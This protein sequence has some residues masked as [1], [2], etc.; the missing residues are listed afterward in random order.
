MAP[1]AQ[2]KRPTAA[3][4]KRPAAAKVAKVAKVAKASAMKTVPKKKPAAVG[5]KAKATTA[6]RGA[7][8]MKKARKSE[9]VAPGDLAILGDLQ[10]LLLG[11]ERR[12]DRRKRCEKMLTE[13]VPWLAVEF[14]R[15]SDG[16]SDVIPD[17][18]VAKTWNTKNNSLY[19]SYEDVM[20]KDGKVLYTAAQFSKPGVDYEFSPGERGCA[21]S[22]YRMWQRVAVSD[23]PMLIL[24]D[25]VQLDF[26]R[27]DSS[28]MTGEIFTERL[29]LGMHEAYSN[30]ADVLYLGWSGFRDGNYK[31]IKTRG[32]PTTSGILRKAEYVWTTVAYVLWP[33]GAK[34]LL[35]KARPMNQPVD[36]FM[37]WESREGRLSSWV[38]LDVGDA[39]DTWSGGIVTQLDFTGDSDIKKSDGGDQGDDPTFY[40]AKKPTPAQP[41]AKKDV[42]MKSADAEEVEAVAE[43]DAAEEDDQ[44]EEAPEEPVPARAAA[45]EASAQEEAAEASQRSAE[46]DAPAEEGGAEEAAAADEEEAA[47]EEEEEENAEEAAEEA[48][49]EGAPE[50]ATAEDAPA[51]D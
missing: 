23:T 28:R 3:V 44:D 35:A 31:H 30:G 39:D 11:L 41:A 15:A 17:K 48:P 12:P 27:T 45:E 29:A 46:A 47:E 37:G 1:K 25:D 5:R 19:G 24:E 6:A 50:E 26:E 51:E 4:L 14:F 16:K 22:H 20:G 21:H 13:H 9:V 43:G 36:N 34:K 2:M 8:A 7:P 33:A 18:E 38:L 40:L 10:A 32:R 42:E 49:K